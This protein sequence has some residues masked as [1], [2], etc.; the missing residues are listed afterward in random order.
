MFKQHY[1][2]IPRYTKDVYGDKFPQIEMRIPIKTMLMPLQK[3]IIEIDTSNTTQFDGE[4]D[5]LYRG[6]TYMRIIEVDMTVKI[7]VDSFNFVYGVNG[8]RRF[9]KLQIKRLNKQRKAFIADIITIMNRLRLEKE[10]L[11]KIMKG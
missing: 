10:I 8:S 2:D 6:D 5:F 11:K 4:Y 1:D 9:Y 3:N 7:K